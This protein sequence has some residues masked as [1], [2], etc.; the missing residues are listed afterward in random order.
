MNVEACVER[1][2][3]IF[4]DAELFYG[5]GTDNAWDEAVYLVFTVLGLPFGDDA[6]SRRAVAQRQVSEPEWQR[7]EALALRRRDERLPMAYVLGEAWFAGLP[8]HVDERVLVP[9]SPIAELI[10]Q[11]YQPLLNAAPARVLDLCT[12][13]GCIGIATA[14][15]FPQAQVDLADISVDALAVAQQNIDRHGLQ[16]TVNTVCADLFAG[17]DGRYDLIVS[18]PPYV[19]AEEVAELPPEYQREP[20]LGLLSDEDGLAIPLQIL[21][22]AADYLSPTGVLVLELGYTW[23]L[24]DQRYPQFPVTWLD[25]DSG[26]EGVLAITRDALIRADS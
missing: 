26:G 1:S 7:I 18:N 21:R 11:Q 15:A 9:R 25:F 8:F 4:D 12:G 10:L 23:A 6:D 13:S 19:S 22:Q 3:S 17:V 5:H 14:L 16:D 20:A 24:L 2:C